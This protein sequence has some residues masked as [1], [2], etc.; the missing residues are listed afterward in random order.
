MDI[1]YTKAK[2]LAVKLN[3]KYKCKNI[4]QAV[5]SGPACAKDADIIVTAT[6]ATNPIVREC[7][8]KPHCHIVCKYFT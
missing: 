3:K 5:N 8:L 1:H 7:W 2:K 4:F 6:F